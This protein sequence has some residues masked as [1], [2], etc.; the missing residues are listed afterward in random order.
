ME[1]ETI[2]SFEITINAMNKLDARIDNIWAF[3]VH[4]FPELKEDTG[5]NDYNDLSEANIDSQFEKLCGE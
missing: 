2:T 4:K 3:L 5:E 1:N